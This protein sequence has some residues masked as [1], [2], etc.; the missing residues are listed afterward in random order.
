MIASESGK[1][2][3]YEQCGHLILCRTFFSQSSADRIVK[4]HFYN[5]LMMYKIIILCY[6]YLKKLGMKTKCSE[7]Y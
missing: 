6:L 1:N 4:D 2:D 3:Y 7:C 5:N